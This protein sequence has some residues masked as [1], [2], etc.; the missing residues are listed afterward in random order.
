MSHYDDRCAWCN[1]GIDE[2][3]YYGIAIYDDNGNIVGYEYICRHC[4]GSW[5]W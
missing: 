1:Q 2:E 4:L 5:H 3:E